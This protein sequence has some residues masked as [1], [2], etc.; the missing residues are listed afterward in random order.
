VQRFGA[1]S[2]MIERDDHIPPLDEL[3]LEVNRTRKI[4]EKI[5]PPLGK[6]AG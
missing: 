3:L 2:T 4:A 1:V 5:L 6:Q